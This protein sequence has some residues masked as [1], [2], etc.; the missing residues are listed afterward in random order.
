MTPHPSQNAA[1]HPTLPLDEQ[2]LIAFH[3]GEP[4][5][6]SDERSVRNR[7]EHDPAFA[8]LSEEIAHT[9]R[10]FSALP[11]PQPDTEAA[12]QRLRG[13][14]PPFDRQAEQPKAMGG[15]L[16]RLRIFGYLWPVPVAAALLVLALCTYTAGVKYRNRANP[17]RPDSAGVVHL[18][19]PQASATS[20][21]ETAH[22]DRAERWLT[23]VNHATSPLDGDTR[24]EGQQLLT[25]NAVYLRD[26]RARGDLPDA[27]V[28]DRLDRVLTTS[29]HPT[30]AGLQLRLDMNT[31]GLLF[32]VRILR[33]NHTA[34]TGDTQ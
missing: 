9:L 31:D 8:A 30:E 33:Q 7:L 28:L 2:Q 18:R 11:V 12:W 22:L 29:N 24:A 16:D 34:P 6:P 5:S 1:P 4:L 14:L 23:V 13:T 15:L 3:L 26:A 19:P 20:S 25:E 10:V 32:Q 17:L 21:G 27:A